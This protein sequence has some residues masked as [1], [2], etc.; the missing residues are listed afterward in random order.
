LAA[1]PFVQVDVF[2]DRPGCGNGLAVVLDAEGMD[3]AAMQAFANWTNLSEST[4]VLPPTRAGADY[5]L[6]I[7][8]PVSELPFAGHPSVG[9]AHALV[10]SGRAVPRAGRLV[11]DCAAGALPIQV[12]GDGD[13]RL[14]SVRAPR[15]RLLDV[16]AGDLAA[17]RACLATAPVGG[18]APTLVDNGPRFWCCELA[19]EATVRGFVPDLDAI[20]ALMRASGAVGY[21]IFARDGCG[22]LAVRVFCP[23]DGIPEDPVTGAANAAI[24]GLLHERGALRELGDRYRVSQGREVGRDGRID[25]RIDADGEAWIGGRTITVIRGDVRW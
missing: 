9:T 1:R 5:R 17:A 15:A 3:A 24:A 25:V 11:Q 8:T 6:R 2:A 12:D 20:A 13:A 18:L 7:F 10:E 23:A 19:D 22:G 21:A 14:V 4:F 16:P